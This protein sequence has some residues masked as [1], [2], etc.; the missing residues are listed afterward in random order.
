[1]IND[2]FIILERNQED[3]FPGQ[4]KCLAVDNHGAGRGVGLRAGPRCRLSG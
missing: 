3:W 2:G 4:V 1:L